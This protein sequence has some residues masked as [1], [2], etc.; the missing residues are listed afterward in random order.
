MGR[1]WRLPPVG[2]ANDIETGAF[3]KNIEIQS[4]YFWKPCFQLRSRL[5]VARMVK[6][7]GQTMFFLPDGTTS[8]S[9]EDFSKGG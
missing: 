8:E 6:V 1:L 7:D 5:S 3:E 2:F 4:G 9:L